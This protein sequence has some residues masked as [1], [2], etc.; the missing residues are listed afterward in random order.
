M[1]FVRIACLCLFSA[2]PL[3]ADDLTIVSKHTRGDGGPTT[4]TSYYTSEK[5]RMSTSDGND[6]VADYQSGTIMMIDN[7]KK[8]Y[9]IMTRQEMEAMAAQMQSKMKEMDAG[10]ASLPPA[11]REK[12]AAMTGGAG[13]PMGEV[14]VTKGSGTRTIAGYTCQNWNVTMG[15]G[16]HQESCVPTDLQFPA[17][18][19]EAQKSFYQSMA[20]AAGPMGK[21]M[22]SAMEKFKE[23]KGFPLATNTTMKIMGKSIDS[24]TEVTEIKKGAVPSTVFD[25]PAGYKKVDSPMAKMGKS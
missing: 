9:S 10:M 3:L 17:G 1:R 18:M 8:E 12:M 22:T 7:K 2:A 14:T 20:G 19:F 13:G 23:M 25:V 21:F 5:M 4:G 16:M 15:E 11:V 6:M 24:S